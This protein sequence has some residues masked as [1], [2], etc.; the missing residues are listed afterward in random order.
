MGPP[1]MTA[2]L[3]AVVVIYLVEQPTGFGPR[4]SAALTKL[5]PQDIVATDLLRMERLILPR[6]TGNSTLEADFIRFLTTGTTW[7]A[8]D[9]AVFDRALELRAKY[10]FLKTPDSLHLAVAI[11]QRCDVFVTNEPKL[12]R[13]TEL[14]VELI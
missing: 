12:A 2:Y 5:G 8:L 9:T 10:P 4:A 7:A 3:D 13:V 6:R 1:P 14:R 11:N